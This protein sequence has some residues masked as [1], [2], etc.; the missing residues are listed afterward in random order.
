MLQEAI[1]KIARLAGEAKSIQVIRPA[2]EP[3]HVYLLQHPEGYDR[4]VAEPP[5]R[6]HRVLSLESL[7]VL[8]ENTDAKNA[9][10]WYSRAGVTFVFNDGDR[11][12]TAMLE[13][14]LSKPVETLLA[15]EKDQR[16][17]NQTDLIK[18]LRTTFAECLDPAGNLLEI[19]RRIKFSA[20]RSGE[21]VVQHGKASVG[22]SLEAE[23]TGTGALPEYITL[24]VPIFAQ[25]WAGWRGLVRCA[26]EP[27]AATETFQVIPLPGQIEAAIQQA[28]DRLGEA[29]VARL[30]DKVNVYHGCP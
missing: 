18:M 4:C 11:R 10:I 28:E 27:N 25:A 8:A 2:G 9:V 19:L 12:D 3:E 26:F 24:D 29:L 16:S 23:L 13:L 15:L 22:R 6:R 30:T 5:P 7:M 14:R 17:F 1:E 20:S 21:A